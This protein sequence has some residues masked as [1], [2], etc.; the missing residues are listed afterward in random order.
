MDNN[1]KVLISIIAGALAIAVA[2][3]VI[4]WK[5][6]SIKSAV[7]K[8]D[9]KPGTT[10]S[11]SADDNGS[12]NGGSTSSGNTE[13]NTET[14]DTGKKTVKVENVTASASSKEIIVPIYATENPGM[15]ATRLFLTYDTEAFSFV[16]CRGG[17]IFDECSG[18]FNEAEKT[19]SVVALEKDGLRLISGAGVI[20]N[21]VL[22]PTSKAKAGTYTVNVSEKSEFA[23]LNDNLVKVKAEAGNIIIQ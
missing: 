13:Y 22:K 11:Q 17:E 8:K 20:V 4:I 2:V 14:K 9:N 19:L 10:E 5:W 18:N 7:T 1:K 15:A 12:G 6:P 23:G 21:V 3:G 16:E